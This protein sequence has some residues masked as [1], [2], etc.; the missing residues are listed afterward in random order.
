MKKSDIKIEFRPIDITE[1]GE[2][3]KEMDP[4]TL[5]KLTREIAER[6][7]KLPRLALFGCADNDHFVAN[8]Q[9][10]CQCGEVSVS[11]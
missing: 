1:L 3:L 6:A 10:R 8:G 11:D 9:Q 7:Q 4:D 2:V 5:L